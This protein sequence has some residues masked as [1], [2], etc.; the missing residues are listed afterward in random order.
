MSD[1][2]TTVQNAYRELCIQMHGAGLA[3]RNR[4]GGDV[5]A[6]QN[7]GG[8]VIS[9][10]RINGNLQCKANSPPPTGGR[11]VVGGNKED[12]CRRL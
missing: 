1:F 5:Q 2:T 6:F 9:S 10:N 7:T 8:V 12:Q 11:N 4:V 3:L